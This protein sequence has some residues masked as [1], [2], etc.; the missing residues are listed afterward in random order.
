M[1]LAIPA[2]F[3]ANVAR[4]FTLIG[5]RQVFFPAVESPQLHY[6][7]GFLWLIPVVW[8]FFPRGERRLLP[9]TVETLHL[10]A[11]FSLLAP[12]ISAPGGN[13]VALCTLLLLANA[14]F[15]PSRLRHGGIA[16]M[17]WVIVA[18]LIA[19]ARMESLWLPWLILCP[20]ITSVTVVGTLVGAALLPGTIPL[21]AMHPVAQWVILL[22]AG[23]WAWQQRRPAK[24][25]TSLQ[26]S[27]APALP[28][29]GRGLAVAMVLLVPF[30]ASPVN[31][32][33]T[34]PA[35]PPSS[36]MPRD[37]GANSYRV[38][39]VGQAPDLDLVWFEPTGEGRHHT[40]EVCM[41]YRGVSVQPTPFPNVKTDGKLWMREFFLQPDGLLFTYG[42]YLKRTFLP[43]S[44]AG[45]HVIASCPVDAM[46]AE[47]FAELSERSAGELMRLQKQDRIHRNRRALAS[48]WAG[49]TPGAE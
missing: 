8:F 28:G 48:A 29:M 25:S 10:A 13:L 40:L 36:V 47:V 34:R 12:L 30:A 45:V 27:E 9:Y 33:F 39:L 42:D 24:N 23:A 7:M 21:L 49:R 31:A 44:A 3:A 15:E 14:R 22:A 37:L 2:A 6:F 16:L 4:I 17:G 11:A 18:V 38:R 46:S 20:A 43:F 1:V 26:S 5:Y 35:M 41:R 32:F 19:G